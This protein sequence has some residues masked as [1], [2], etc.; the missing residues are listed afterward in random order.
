M[1]TPARGTTRK[2][3]TRS[4]SLS[5]V[6]FAGKTTC[7]P[8]GNYIRRQSVLSTQDG[9]G[10][11]TCF[12]SAFFLF[13]LLV[14]PHTNLRKDKTHLPASLCHT[15]TTGHHFF[16]C[17]HLSTPHTEPSLLSIQPHKQ[18]GSSDMCCYL[19]NTAV[20]KKCYNMALKPGL[21]YSGMTTE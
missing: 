20:L 12:T 5:A 17:S 16:T 8:M 19:V 2:K 6:L 21:M 10:N 13:N 9:P 15:G 1:A 3:N 4:P 11:C 14:F 18:R 7:I